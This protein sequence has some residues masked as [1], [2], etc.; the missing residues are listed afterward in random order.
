MATFRK[1]GESWEAQIRR[2]G[3]PAQ[4]RTFDTKA[5]AQRWATKLEREMDERA[6]TGGQNI[7]GEKMFERFRDEVSPER[8]GAKWEQDRINRVRRECKWLQLRAEEILPEH[9]RGYR[10]ERLKQVSSGSVKREMNV[11]SGVFGYAIKEGWVTLQVNPVS[12]V[13]KPLENKSRTQRVTD[14]EL[15]AIVGDWKTAPAPEASKDYLVFAAWFAVETAMRLG[16]ICK[17]K[18]GDVLADY[19]IVRNPKNGVDRTV[20]LSPTAKH[21]VERLPVA[22]WLFPITAALMGVRWREAT[23]SAGL[24]HIHFHDLRREAASRLAKKLP[25]EALAKMT[26]H[27][28]IKLLLKVYYAPDPVELAARL[29]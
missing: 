11:I 9:I 6:I 24:Q 28:D 8:K 27:L 5:Q 14:E 26:G 17:L 4:S 19:V 21:I 22:E 20:P 10:D 25:I 12:L 1:R 15:L 16:E 7:T 29:A 23:K 3:Y 18:R 13:K 2:R